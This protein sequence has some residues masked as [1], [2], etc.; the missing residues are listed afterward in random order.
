M[1]PFRTVI[2]QKMLLCDIVVNSHLQP[3]G[4]HSFLAVSLTSIQFFATGFLAWRQF[5]NHV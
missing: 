4:Y 1:F 3:E 5:Y 2:Q